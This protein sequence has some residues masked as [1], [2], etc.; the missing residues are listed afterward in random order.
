M[1]EDERIE[2]FLR[3]YKDQLIE[4]CTLISKF[5]EKYLQAFSIILSS[6]AEKEM[7]SKMVR[8][9]GEQGRI[10]TAFAREVDPQVEAVHNDLIFADYHWA[11]LR[12]VIAVYGHDKKAQ[13]I[14]GS[15]CQWWLIVMKQKFMFNVHECGLA[16]QLGLAQ[17]AQP[18][19]KDAAQNILYKGSQEYKEASSFSE[20]QKQIIK[21]DPSNRSPDYLQLM[22]QELQTRIPEE[23]KRYE[24]A[25]NTY[26]RELRKN[27][28]PGGYIVNDEIIEGGR[29]KSF[30]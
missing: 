30:T 13:E 21:G 12:L 19:S 3:Q 11:T 2:F 9:W 8:F 15:P 29:G 17:E 22:A 24:D 7:F 10:L 14:W 1:T 25:F 23:Y 18:M 20:E 5:P 16:K 26:R 6:D 4:C 28:P 27:V